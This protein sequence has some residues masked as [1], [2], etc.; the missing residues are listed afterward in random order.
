MNIKERVAIDV[1]HYRHPHGTR[2][3]LL[4]AS[5]LIGNPVDT[6]KGEKLGRVIDLMLDTASGSVRY[7]VLSSGGFLGLGGRL[8][9]VPWGALELDLRN[10]R[11]VLDVNVARFKLAPAFDKHNW[12][13]ISDSSWAHDIHAYY[14]GMRRDESKNGEPAA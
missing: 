13:D 11:F 6:R 1:T 10:K 2:T 3:L 14:E 7:A 9:A 4:S 8:F 12:P 5:T